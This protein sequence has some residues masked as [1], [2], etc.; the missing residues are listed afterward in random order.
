MTA[1]ARFVCPACG[2][3]YALVRVEADVVEPY[4]HL[5]CRSCGGPLDAYEGRF[6]LK[7][8]LISRPR[9]TGLSR[10]TGP[11]PIEHPPSIAAVASKR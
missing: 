3:E 5:L 1:A 10:T 4:G 7:Y 2:A 9:R 11:R 6:I 8:F